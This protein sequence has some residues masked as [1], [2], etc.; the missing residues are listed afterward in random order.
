MEPLPLAPTWT[1]DILGPDFQR[2]TIELPVDPDAQP[3]AIVTVI[4]YL[5]DN[6]PGDFQS[7]PAILYIPGTS[8]Y[9]FHRHVAEYFHGQGY[10]FYAVDLRK[11]ARSWQPGQRWYYVSDLGIYFKDLREAS[12]QLIHE[13]HKNLFILG[14]SLGGLLT[15]IWLDHLRISE[16][17]EIL[18]RLRGAILNSPWLDMFFATPLLPVIRRVIPFMALHHPEGKIHTKKLVAY[19]H[20]IH[21][22]FAGEWDFCLKY[23]PVGGHNKYW[24]WASAVMRSID[25]VRSGAVNCPV[26]LLVLCSMRSYLNKPLGP[27]SQVCDTV[28]DVDQIMHWS[29]SLGEK[30]TT[31]PI[32]DAMHDIFLSKQGVRNRALRTCGQWLAQQRL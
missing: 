7:R 5:P 18:P 9:F 24:G 22:D 2:L 23:K 21:K 26:P 31:I 29:T 4:R 3:P 17:T 32:E 14:H 25:R 16:D 19:V 11:C 8:D 20:S 27:K 15:S 13:G 1:E 30:V 28:L 12:L 10:A 6:T